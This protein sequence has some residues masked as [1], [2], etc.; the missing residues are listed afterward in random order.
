MSLHRRLCAVL[1]LLTA[2]TGY[3]LG[4]ETAAPE[5]PGARI[6]V[7]R[8]SIHLERCDTP[9]RF[10]GGDIRRFERWIGR[11]IEK[12]SPRLAHESDIPGRIVV[13]FVIDTTGR[14]TQIEALQHPDRSL[15]DKVLR[16]LE[17]SPRWKP[18]LSGGRTIPVEVLLPQYSHRRP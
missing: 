6:V 17:Q 16:I 4:Q 5:R 9:P 18:G 14:L 7:F 8:D 10:R 15:T 12:I 3:A 13:S 2:T 1:L 11:K